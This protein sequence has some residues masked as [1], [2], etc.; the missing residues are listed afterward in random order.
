MKNATKMPRKMS[1]GRSQKC[2]TTR[3]IVI[4]PTFPN[5]AQSSQVNLSVKHFV[6][7]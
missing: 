1:F 7:K 5:H 6:R 3:K 2:P 4:N